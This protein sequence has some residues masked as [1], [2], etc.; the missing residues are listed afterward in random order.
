M[1]TLINLWASA[2]GI[3]Q[4]IS[5]VLPFVIGVGTLLCGLGGFCLE[6]GHAENAAAMLTI[7][8][9]INSDPNAGLVIAGLGALGVHVNHSANVAAVQ[10]NTSQIA[11]NT[12]GVAEQ[13]SKTPQAGQ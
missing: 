5:S 6:F 9:N 2:N 13:A 3:W 7:L 12:A 11:Q 8:K 4:K 10:A 1:N